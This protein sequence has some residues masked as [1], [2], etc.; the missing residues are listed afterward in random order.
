MIILSAER[1]NTSIQPRILYIVTLTFRGSRWTNHVWKKQ[2]H[3]CGDHKEGV[4][5]VHFRD[6]KMP[7]PQSSHW[8]VSAGA[9]SWLVSGCPVTDVFPNSSVFFLSLNVII[10]S[11]RMSV[12][13]VTSITD[14]PTG[15]SRDPCCYQ[16]FSHPLSWPGGKTT[17]SNCLCSMAWT[18]WL[19]AGNGI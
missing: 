11:K 19:S 1:K 5:D 13:L 4:T 7:G 10:W 18:T 14:T 17:S 12:F 3:Q 2:S 16:S 15:F 8:V 9:V 6:K